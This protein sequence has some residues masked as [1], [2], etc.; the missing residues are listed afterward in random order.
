MR[1]PQIQ[2]ELDFLEKVKRNTVVAIFSDDSLMETLVLKGGNAMN[3]VYGVQAR[4]S[5]DIDLSMEH[6]FDSKELP[7]I[8][9]KIEAGLRSIFA[10]EG[11]L[12][13]DVKFEQRPKRIDK[14]MEGFWG[15]YRVTFKVIDKQS[16]EKGSDNIEFLRRNAKVVGEDGK[17]TFRIDISKFEH[18][19]E[20][21]EEELDGYTIFVYPP[22]MIVFEKVRAICQQMPEYEEIIPVKRSPRAR[23]FFDICLLLDRFPF[24]IN[25]PENIDLL[26]KIFEIKRVPFSFL[27][28][29]GSQREYHRIDYDSLKDTVRPGIELKDFDYYFDYVVR[30]FN[31]VKL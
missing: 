25:T 26:K 29:I 28:K 23:D 6:Q 8:H 13:F 9:E 15:G 16:Y 19:E 3:I 14:N 17:K 21:V 30:S 1:K 2:S 20:K 7:A 5:V 27:N 11:Y 12:A 31:E 22:K 24:K 10:E 4:A 18:C